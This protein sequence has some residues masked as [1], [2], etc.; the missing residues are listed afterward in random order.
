MIYCNRL[1][2][3]DEFVISISLPSFI[4]YNIDQS[5]F[6][7]GG[8]FLALPRLGRYTGLQRPSP[9]SMRQLIGTVSKS[10]QNIAEAI[11]K[12]PCPLHSLIISFPFNIS[13]II[14]FSV[15]YGDHTPLC[16]RVLVIITAVA[17]KFLGYNHS[18]V[19]LC[20]DKA[21]SH[22]KLLLV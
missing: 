13:A 21:D 18:S 15:N 10:Y 7:N 17:T 5:I 3:N 8:I 12:L 19:L 16:L 14:L 1:K 6:E 20:D 9:L 11:V 2:N 4:L 22:L